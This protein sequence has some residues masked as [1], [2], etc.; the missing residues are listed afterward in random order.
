L[1]AVNIKTIV[2]PCYVPYMASVVH[3]LFQSE[4]A[5]LVVISVMQETFRK[6]WD[7]VL[8]TIAEDDSV[9]AFR[10][11]NERRKKFG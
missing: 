2:Q 5:G 10:R 7:G 8:W 9:A 11:W 3:F 6:A 1:A 4:K